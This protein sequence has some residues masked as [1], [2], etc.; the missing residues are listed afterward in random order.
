LFNGGHIKTD[1]GEGRTEPVELPGS[2]LPFLS[3]Q[4]LASVED[5][6]LRHPNANI[7]QLP[8]VH[9]GAQRDQFVAILITHAFG[10][11]IIRFPNKITIFSVVDQNIG[12]PCD[13]QR[14]VAKPWV[15]DLW[16]VLI[17]K[18]TPVAALVFE[19]Y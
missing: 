3:R 19:D 15:K 16:A 9:E 1:V 17:L 11:K 2:K 8:Q 14:S 7:P 6:A 18:S 4:S 13:P 5:L 12:V 10:V